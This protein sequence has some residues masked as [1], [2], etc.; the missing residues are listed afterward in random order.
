MFFNTRRALALMS[1]AFLVSLLGPIFQPLSRTHAAIGTGRDIVT[2][3][4]HHLRS[5]RNASSAPVCPN[6]NAGTPQQGVDVSSY[7][8]SIDWTRVK[9]AGKSF[10]Y[11]RVGD[12]TGFLDPDFQ[13]N[14]TGMK[15][16]GIKPGAYLF[17]EPGADPVAQANALLS[18]LT[19][20]G[21]TVGDL[22]PA[23]DVEVAG[24][25]QPALVAA[26]LQTMVNT[27]QT[28]LGASPLI[29]TAAPAW[30]SIVG[31]TA[32]FGDPLWVANWGVSCPNLPPGWANWA[33]WQYRDN[34]SVPGITGAVD[35][36]ESNGSTL[37]V[38]NPVLTVTALPTK[39]GATEGLPFSGQVAAGVNP[40]PSPDPLQA[41]IAWGDGTTSS[42]TV[43]ANGKTFTVNGT[44]TYTEEGPYTVTITVN[45]TQGHNATSGT[46]AEVQ[47]AFLALSNLIVL[48]LPLRS[49]T[50]LATFTDADPG[51]KVSDYTAT[52]NWGDG[53]PGGGT[54]TNPIPPTPPTI[55]RGIITKNIL[56][57]GFHVTGALFYKQAGTYTVTLTVQDRGS[58]FTATKTIQIV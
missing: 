8:G 42:G 3:A 5:R 7:D 32:F 27:I 46:T 34:G 51:G 24:G 57:K 28:A 14:F 37:P 55:T 23:I 25:Q 53:S 33:I 6:P 49:A 43:S 12:G 47:D 1:I 40:Y 11:A 36:N 56:G 44:H 29:Y 26:H 50:V 4:D 22:L 35:L 54:M 39:I 41:T 38:Y 16:A 17:F 30:N 58:S 13:T 2:N 21:F 18:A 48:S 45:D 31:S 19:Q 9:N 10:G 20:A 52:I 15:S